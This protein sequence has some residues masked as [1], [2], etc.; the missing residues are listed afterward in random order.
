MN[1]I[2]K[3]LILAVLAGGASSYAT[4]TTWPLPAGAA[5]NTTY[6]VKIRPL[7]G[8]WQSVDVYNAGVRTGATTGTDS[9][10]VYFDSDEPVEV[11]VT[12][13]S[14]NISTVDIRPKRLHINPVI[15][16]SH[17]FTFVMDQPKKISV[18][19]NGDIYDNL[20]IFARSPE[21]DPITG[22]SANVTYYGPGYHLLTG[23]QVL[24]TGQTMY[25]AGGA[26]VEIDLQG[27]ASL[28]SHIFAQSKSSITIRGR[29]VIYMPGPSYGEVHGP[30]GIRLLGCSN[31][32]IEGITLLKQS[33]GW[34]NDAED[35]WYAV[36]ADLGIITMGRNSDGIDIVGSQHVVVK[37]CFVRAGDDA[38]TVKS[39]TGDPGMEDVVF[40][41]CVAWNDITS[42]P[43]EIGFELRAPEVKDITFRNI[44]I[45]HSNGQ[46]PYTSD[47]GTIDI[48]HG[49]GATLRNILFENIYVENI[50][51][52]GSN[53]YKLV[54]GSIVYD[55]NWSLLP[56]DE[57]RGEGRNIRFKNI[58]YTGS[59]ASGMS[60]YN[61]DHTFD[62]VTFE[63]FYYNNQ[64]ATTP[65]QANLSVGNYAYNVGFKKTP[66]LVAHWGFD[67]AQGDGILDQSPFDNFGTLNG[68][69][70]G[71]GV[72]GTALYP[73]GSQKVAI[74]AHPAMDLSDGQFNISAYVFF[75]AVFSGTQGVL[76]YET[77]GPSD[78]YPSIFIIDG[79]DIEFGFGTGSAW[80]GKRI[81]NVVEAG[82]VYHLRYVLDSVNSTEKFYLNDV[83]VYFGIETA[84]PMAQ[85]A[86]SI[87]G[88]GSSYFAGAIDEVMIY[89]QAGGGSNLVDEDFDIFPGSSYFT[90]ENYGGGA[91]NTY[92]QDTGSVLSGANSLK[93]DITNSGDA[94][95]WWALQVRAPLILV[96]GDVLEVSFQVKSTA[97]ISFLSRLEGDVSVVPDGSMNEV[98]DVLAGEI[99]TVTYQM[100]AILSDGGG[101]FMFALGDSTAGAAEVWIDAITIKKL[102]PRPLPPAIDPI[103][104]DPLPGN[105]FSITWNTVAGYDYVLDTKTNLTDTSWTPDTVVPG[106]AGSVTVTTT[107][108]QVQ[109]FYRVTSE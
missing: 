73:N 7:G 63:N 85:A 54:S 38:L 20:Q 27:N 72:V 39:W 29:G 78:R 30:Q 47:F 86:F 75:A 16:S 11:E 81:N 65:A 76:G 108:D 13:N 17:V 69:V 41:D 56:G 37:D 77:S 6:G 82:K 101:T 32:R 102:I 64:L 83:E 79:T 93:L 26:F 46:S 33:R 43:I 94:G 74:N 14:K 103:I 4:I 80:K 59:A 90:F 105:E 40:Q 48:S 21:V 25:I 19:V 96:A 10:M 12:I 35:C 9:S 36:Y 8:T 42:H 50:H 23:R 68:A 100:A 61:N 24:Q 89:N 28:D 98:I 58:F 2:M 107:V 106:I 22:P 87:G 66:G 84:I 67:E 31:V 99:K 91:V 1:R 104:L 97:D 18:E 55:S 49:D 92:S 60:G 5:A 95:N 34:T 62:G 3:I 44:D 71:V 70:R 52:T 51:Y 57:N 53:P 109:S 45:I 15:A 88:V